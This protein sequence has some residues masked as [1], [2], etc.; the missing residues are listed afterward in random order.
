M[1]IMIEDV[2]KKKKSLAYNILL[3]KIL[4]IKYRIYPQPSINITSSLLR[5]STKVSF[6]SGHPLN[7]SKVVV[8]GSFS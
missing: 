7:H 6:N 8:I 2:K 1:I 5:C 4:I 3:L